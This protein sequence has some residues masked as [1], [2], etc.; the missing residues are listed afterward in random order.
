MNGGRSQGLEPIFSFLVSPHLI[1]DFRLISGNNISMY[2]YKCT[3]YNKIKKSAVL[4]K[5]DPQKGVLD[6]TLKLNR[7][8][9]VYNYL[10]CLYTR[11]YFDDCFAHSISYRLIIII[12]DDQKK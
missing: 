3:S 11:Y 1:F 4:A 7:F 6:R 5:L 8:I 10:V 9:C 12:S 2:F